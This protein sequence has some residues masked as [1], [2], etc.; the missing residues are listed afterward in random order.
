MTQLSKRQNLQT[1]WQSG[2]LVLSR[3][4][5][6]DEETSVLVLAPAS[7]RPAPATIARLEHEYSLR[8]QLESDWAIRPLALNHHSGRPMLILEDPGGEPLDRLMGR[9]MEL[10]RFLRVAISLSHAL[11]KLHKRGLIHKDIKPANILVDLTSGAA[12][13]TGLGIASR[14]PRERQSP[15]PPEIIAGTLAYMAPE[16]TGRMNRSI[17][18][19][20]DLYSLGI[21]F[22]EMLT[23]A[24]PFKATDPI[25][26]VH[27]QIARQPVPPHECAA[28]IPRPLSAVVI[29]L[30]AK[31]AEERYQTA[32]GVEGALRRCL[33]AW[34]SFGRIDPLPLG[35]QDVSDRLMIPERLYGRHRET[36]A[37]IASFD[38]VVTDGTPELVLVSGYSGIGKSSVVNELQRV[39]VR[40]R[41]IFASGKF[42]QYKRDIPYATLVQ[43]FQSVVRSLL[44]QSEA[45]LGRWRD[46]LREALGVNG[47]LVVNLIPELELVIGKQPPVVNLPPQEAQNRFQVIFLRFLG[48]FARAE[49]PLVLFLDDLQWMDTGTAEVLSRLTSEPDVHHLLLVG[50]YRDNEVSPSHPLARALQEIRGTGGKVVEIVLAPLSIDDIGQLVM[51]SLYCEPDRARPLA[52]LIHEKTGG[53]PFFAILF[54]TALAE[55]GLLTFDAVATAWEWDIDRIRTKSYTDNVVDLMVGKLRKFR[56]PTQEALKHLACVGNVADIATLKLVY[57]ETEEAMHA[58][59]WEA[60]CAGLVLHLDSSYKFMHDRIQQAAYLLIPQENRAEVHLRIG[61]VLLRSMTKD[62]LAEH[63]FDV[64]NQFNRGEALLVDRDEKVQVATIELRAGRKAKASAAYASAR[65][66]FGAGMALLDERAWDTQHELMFS[67]WLECSE[68]EFLSGDFDRA[69]QLIAVLLER[70]AS[71]IDRAAAYHLKVQLHIVK[72]EYPQAVASALTCLRLFGIDVPAH[73]T[74]EQVQA[75]YEAVW[76]NLEGHP[77]E[78]LIDQPLMTDVELQAAMRVLSAANPPAYF[79]DFLLCCL[80]RCRMVNVSLQYGTS[81]DSAYG[82]A[83][84][85]F[86]LGP[87]FNRYSDGFRFCRLACDLVDRRDWIAYQARMYV[88]M[89]GVAIWTQPIATAIDFMQA[90]FRVASETGDLTHACYSMWQAIAYA[91]QRNDP[92]DAVWSESERS[93]DFVRRAKFRDVADIIVSQQRFVATMQGRTRAFSTFN[94]EYFNEADFEAR[95]TGDRMPIMTFF[96]WVFKLKS[97]FLSSDYTEALAVAEKAKEFLWGAFGEIMLVDYFYYSALTV[98]ALYEKGSAT[99]KKEW[100]NLLTAHRKKLDEWAMNYRPTF[101]GKHA[102]V[103]AEIARVDNRN[104]DAMRL[105]EEAIRAAYENGFVE[106]GGVANELAG[107]FYLKRGIE[108]VAYSYLRDARYCYLRWGALG[109]VRQLDERYPAIAEQSAPPTTTTIGTPIEQLDLGT[110]MKVSHAVAEEIVLENL[111]ETLMVVAIEHAGADRGLLILPRE[112]EFLIAAEAKTGRDRIDVELQ[113]LLVTPSDLPDSLLR[114]VTRTQESVILDDASVQNLFSDDEYFLRHGPRSVLCLPLV[115]QAKLMG[116]LYLENNLA[117]GVFT[118]KRLTMLELLASQAA[119]SLDHARLYAGLGRLNAELTKENSDRR[120]AEEALRASEERWRKL[121]ETSSAGIALVALDGH[122]I[123]ANYAL[124]KM[125]G[126]T[127]EELRGLTTPNVTH[128]EDRP[129]TEAILAECAEGPPRSFR[130]TKRYRCKDGR[131]VWADVSS[132]MVPAAGDKPGF[133]AT[134]VVDITER[135]RAEEELRHKEISL[136][137][138]QSELAH[139]SRVTMMGELAASIAHEVSQPLA[140]IVTN[141]NASL[142]WL[143]AESPNLEEARESIRRI[144][145][146]GNRSSDVVSRMR[147]LFKK[148]YTATESLDINQAIEEVVTLTEREAQRSNVTLYM[149]LA[150]DLPPVTGDRVQLQQVVLNLF[151]NGIE[152]MRGLENR[153]RNLIIRTQRGEGG[154]VR[155][156][157]QDSGIGFDPDKAERMFDP[158]HT[159]KPGGLGM[160]LSISRSIVES[161]G[162]RLWAVSNDGPGATFQ[163]TLLERQKN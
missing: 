17:D 80:L 144:I 138:A 105:Y 142:R 47:Q 109:K 92:L 110:V 125:L 119:I 147:T 53:N 120:K 16:Q 71:K 108:K 66:Y 83:S 82:Y 139:V 115:K 102:L 143:R 104:L 98:T 55:E 24:L 136:R 27:C 42:D 36:D 157:V 11:G 35:T 106:D 54:F 148:V 85:G 122:Y 96:Y 87:I 135:K 40:S 9:P 64:A 77:I 153:E 56:G 103:S 91:L 12:W 113:D 129:E 26:W 117:S 23:G 63:L 160:G 22:Y 114:Y 127:E 13:L 118:P 152:A 95:L 163:F 29:K 134:V 162:G 141:A 78:S 76:R 57:G 7:E 101:T 107:Q 5:L 28:E 75:E 45:E 146:D 70:G 25:E 161:H 59:L 132:T 151:L 155:I 116:V 89:G 158:F 74:W 88:L 124:Q 159:T 1:L 19:R 68:C 97:R 2:D 32:A 8:D 69:E 62:E 90:A 140:G 10:G 46:A 72:G 3:S 14:L 112:E 18:S 154:E 94:D 149:E 137:E 49:H 48:V 38:R 60:V 43:A 130:Q 145:R 121:F 51:D 33:T 44:G 73:P 131:V 34:E 61:R 111:I 93:L 79:T 67:L 81:G 31:T 84:F 30:L 52:E 126:Y 37:L 4:T 41:G 39:L 58:A 15:E 128:E 133:F 156:A 100:S 99:E 50:A 65:V 150:P 6:A 21:T 20:S 86:L 123:A